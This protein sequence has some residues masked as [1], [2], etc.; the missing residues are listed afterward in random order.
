MAHEEELGL[1]R[2]EQFAITRDALEAH[3]E[4]TMPES[5]DEIPEMPQDLKGLIEEAIQHYM[6]TGLTREQAR[7]RLVQEMLLQVNQKKE[8]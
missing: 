5:D 6:N 3:V 1:D 7:I 4:E 2:D 8:E